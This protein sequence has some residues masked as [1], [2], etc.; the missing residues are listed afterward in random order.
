MTNPLLADWTTLFALP[1]FGEIAPA[2]FRPAFDAALDQA[3]KEIAAVADDPAEPT[4]A[5]TVE[6]LERSGQALERV[7]AVFF[8]LA[9]AHTN[10]EIEAIRAEIAPRLARFS[11]ETLMDPALFSRMEALMARRDALGLTPEQDRVLELTHRRFLRAG[12]KLDEAAR[13]RM[14]AIMERLATLGTRF[15]KNVLDDERAYAL[16]LAEADLA[17]L[18]GW[19]RGAALEAAKERGLDGWAITLSRSLIE[20]F[21][22][23]SERRDLREQAWRAWTSRGEAGETDNRALVAETLALRHE[24]ARLL[25]FP[26]YATFKLEPEMAK[27][28][29]AVRDLLERVWTPARARAVEEAERLR[30]EAGADDALQ[31]WDWRFWAEKVR[32]RDHDLSDEALKPYLSLDAMIGAAFDVAH[33]LFGLAFRPLP[34][35]PV[36]HPDVR[37]WEVTREGRHVGVFM[38]DYFNRASKRSGAWCSS[39]RGQRKLDGEVRPVVLNVMNFAKAEPALLTFDDAE[40]LFHEFGHAL[41]ALLSD[42]TY[43]SVA[44][45]SVS[46]DFVELPSQLY[47]HWLSAPEVLATHARHVETG[48]PMPAGLIER[49]RAART[50]NQG[51]ATVEYLASA[52]V[53]L[54]LH[55]G[56]PP[57]DPAAREAEVLAEIGMPPEIV[58]RHRTPHFAHVF[59]GEGY[60]SGYYSYMWSE[61]MDADAFAAF[62]ETGDLFSA[63]TARRL[64]SEILSVGGSRDPEQAWLAFRGAPPRVEALLAGRGLAA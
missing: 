40:T 31:P 43:P 62:E 11:A 13:A 45:T 7:S 12:A 30:A 1:P 23:F 4:F 14:G 34:D 38:G 27:T 47:E 48:E 21:L 29:A 51:F 36:H 55:E 19:L 53:D 28:P 2:D 56:E 64:E 59:A 15:A 37:V 44:G 17:G 33:R 6:A 49:L 61:V 3:R 39:F 18:P 63:E 10:D 16:P 42:V 24:R 8:N 60:A 58:M 25:G 32:A 9:G 20:P 46:R 22:A 57:A 26:D 54:A 5:N 35:A 50:F 41:H 52:L